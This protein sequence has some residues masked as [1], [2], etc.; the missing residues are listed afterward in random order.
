MTLGGVREVEEEA[1][2]VCLF[3][4]SRRALKVLLDLGVGVPD[5]RSSST[6]LIIAGIGGRGMF[7]R[8]E[9]WVTD[10]SAFRAAV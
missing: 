7:G 4:E 6:S 8:V 1:V 9:G 5:F 2:G 10:S 3:S